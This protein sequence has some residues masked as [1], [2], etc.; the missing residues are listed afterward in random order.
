MAYLVEIFRIWNFSGPYFPAFGLNTEIYGV[1]VGMWENTDQKN[2]KYG[3]FL[4]SDFLRPRVRVV[5]K[6]LPNIY[7]ENACENS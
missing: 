1:N 6:A 7:D 3:H 2:S 5:F 4:R